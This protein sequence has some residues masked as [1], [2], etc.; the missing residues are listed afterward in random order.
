IA[1]VTAVTP[2]HE[3]GVV[4]RAWPAPLEQPGP[5][6]AH[7]LTWGKYTIEVKE[8]PLRIAVSKGGKVLQ[9]VRFDTYSVAVNFKIGDAPLFGLGE[10]VHPLD[11]RGTRD[12]MV[13][14]QHS[15]DLQTF[16]S[17]VPIPWLISAAG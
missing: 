3:L 5:A 1:P 17:R 9:E 7:T 16:G 4:E 13:N 2:V 8:D 10:G 12:A 11:R 15:P 6:R 14:G